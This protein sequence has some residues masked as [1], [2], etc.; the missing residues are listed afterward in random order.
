[1][2]RYPN[3]R[4]SN[5]KYTPLTFLP[6]N[7]Y[8]QC[9]QSMNKY[10]LLIALLQLWPAITPV[11]PVTTWVPLAVIFSV[12]ALKDAV[13]DWRRY[14]ADREANRRKVVKLT[15]LGHE[16]VSSESLQV[17]DVV[18]VEEGEE[19][20]T[21]LVLLKSSDERGGCY[22]QTANLDGETNLKQR[23]ALDVTQ[24][25]GVDELARLQATVECA[26]PNKNIYA[27]D[28]TI[29]V[30]QPPPTSISSSSSL[31]SSSTPPS[32][33]SP[34]VS[35]FPLTTSQL[36]LQATNLMN[37]RHVYGL[38]VYTGADTKVG[39]NKNTPR[40]K[41]TRLDVAIDRVIVILFCFQVSMIVLWGV[42][43]SILL[44]QDGVARVF[45]LHL[46]RVDWYDPIVIPLRFLLLASM[47][48]PISLKVTVDFIKVLYSLFI[49]WDLHM[50]DERRQVGAE[51]RNTAIAEEL[52]CVQYLMS[53]KTGTLTENVMIMREMSV[54]ERSYG[55]QHSGE[56]SADECHNASLDLDAELLEAVGK[57]EEKVASLLRAMLVCNTV[58]PSRKSEEQR[59]KDR[60]KRAADA[61]PYSAQEVEYTSSSPDELSLVQFAAAVG[62]VLEERAG[63]TLKGRIGV[64]RQTWEVLGVCEFS[65]VRKRMS[66]IVQDSGGEI[67][68]LMKGADDV[69]LSRLSPSQQ[70]STPHW[71]SILDAYARKGLRTLVFAS[72]ALSDTE[73]K[74]WKVR[75]ER[76]NLD[77][78]SREQALARVYEELE[79]D[80]EVLGVTGI[81]DK[82]QED[83]PATLSVLRQAGIK[84][85]MLTGD[86][87]QTAEEIGRSSGLISQDDRVHYI[88]ALSAGE[89]AALMSHLAQLVELDAPVQDAYALIVDGATLSLCLLHQPGEFYRLSSCAV[90]V[91]CCRVTPSQKAAVTSLINSHGHIT[92]AIGDGA[93]DTAMIQV[94]NVGVGINGREGMQAARASDFSIARF[95]YLTRLLLLHGRWSYVRTSWISQYCLYKSMIICLVQLLFAFSSRFSGASFLDSISLVFYNLIYTSL[96]GLFFALEQDL[97]AP[98]LLAS[99]HL[100]RTSRE[101]LCFSRRT[102]V[103]W[104]TRSVYQSLVISLLTY[105]TELGTSG[106][107]LTDHNQIGIALVAYS[108]I[109]LIQCF[110][111]YIEMSYITVL[112]HAIIWL[113]I[114][115]F[116]VINIAVS[117][118]Q[119]S[120]ASGVFV[121]LLADPVYWLSV[122]LGVTLSL[123]P[124]VGAKFVWKQYWPTEVDVAHEAEVNSG[125]QYNRSAIPHTARTLVH[126]P[127]CCCHVQHA[128]SLCACA[129]AGRSRPSAA[130]LLSGGGYP[131]YSSAGNDASHHTARSLVQAV[132]AKRKARQQRREQRESRKGLIAL[133]DGEHEDDLPHHIPHHQRQRGD[134]EEEEKSDGSD[135]GGVIQLSVDDDDDVELDAGEDSMSSVDMEQEEE[136]TPPRR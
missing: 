102:L 74:E 68:L 95:S 37:T 114:L 88:N 131:S 80:C 96:L 116:F 59:E 93:N 10:F 71:R 127:S 73:W 124:V 46:H 7:L 53:D 119:M 25:L 43:G 133:G 99:P 108:S 55:G 101:G 47:M 66:V 122:L 23:A 9:T 94:A 113:T 107:Q 134:D 26:L 83:V 115:A 130:E 110:T 21:D 12:S 106:V 38:V 77:V 126:L 3:N 132:R 60:K 135:G 128:D 56:L 16:T 15:R 42:V 13:D 67:I 40:Q 112:N 6:L 62:F 5:T 19:F 44:Y 45:Y 11:N 97:L 29:T 120:E 86:K 76:A 98:T 85:W 24:R 129:C 82:L 100:Y 64:E 125:A 70:S 14:Q 20:A 92:L 31:P 49:R 72:R 81:E 121:K 79:H 48:I 105:Y 2:Q 22:I 61:N 58:V 136:T 123:L 33:S 69:V 1:M 8:Q 28:S 91:I 78:N 52:G 51:A 17:G 65:S 54:Q 32:A 84:V 36:L 50:W 103:Y 117:A 111:L 41:Y 87:Q 104:F 89:L 30:L 27:F 35:T 57:G 34:S 63:Q 75:W 118:S 109:V 18:Y 90:S 4:I 39:Q